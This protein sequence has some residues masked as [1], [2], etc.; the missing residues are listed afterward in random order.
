[1][2]LKF[3]YAEYVR[4]IK[5]LFGM[6]FIITAV[7]KIQ[8]IVDHTLLKTREKSMQIHYSAKGGLTCTNISCCWE[9]I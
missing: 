3:T 1:M 4:L 8:H 7:A 9:G 2:P 5:Y 6:F